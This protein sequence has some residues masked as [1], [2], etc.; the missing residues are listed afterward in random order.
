M[1][2][3]LRFLFII[4]LLLFLGAWLFPLAF[5]DAIVERVKTEANA[6]LDAELNFE[7]VDLSLISTFPYFGFSLEGLSLDGK[8][9]FEGERLLEVGDFQLKIDLMSVI[10]GE[11]Y[12]IN[13]ISL[14]DVKANLIILENGKSNFDILKA[15][16]SGSPEAEELN[17]ESSPFHMALRSYELENFD[18]TFRDDQSQ[19]LFSLKDLDHQGSGD[20]S[21]SIVNLETQTSISAI[22]FKSEG[23][24]YLKKVGLKADVD[25]SYDQ[26]KEELV[27]AENTMTLN[28][29]Q[30]H[31]DGSVR[32]AE[33]DVHIDM[34]YGSPANSFKDLISLIP[35][36]YYQD[37]SDL[38]TKGQFKLDGLVSGVFNGEKE[39]Y[40]S[41]KL[42]LAVEDA[43]IHYPDLPTAMDNIAI[44][45]KIENLSNKLEATEVNLKS[46][47]ATIG[48][49]PISASFMLKDPMGD[50]NI[51]AEMA[52][53]IDL[54]KISEII[55]LP[56][57]DLAGQIE[58]EFSLATRL[59][60]VEQ[61]NFDL[62]EAEGDIKVKN[63]SAAGDSL[64]LSMEILQS[65][66]TISPQNARLKK[67][68]LR[69]G[70]SD[71][72][73]EGSLDNMLGYA[74]SDD[75]LKGNLN[76]Y[77]TY[78]NM[79]DLLPE[80]EGASEEASTDTT[81][82]TVIRIPKNLDLSLKGRID[83]F[84]Y[85]GLVMKTLRGNVI[86]KDGKADQDLDI[87]ML[88]GSVELKGSYDSKPP[89][90][91]ADMTFK[92]LGCSFFE[93]YQGL[94]MVKSIAP[95]M[96]SI[97]GK[98]SAGLNFQ[99]V[100]GPDM[101]PVLKS[102]NGGGSLSTNKVSG[103]NATMALIAK[104]LNNPKYAQLNVQDVKMQFE[105]ADGQVEVK[106][107][108]FKLA[109][110][111]SDFSGSMGLDQSLDFKLN[112][113]LPLSAIK[114]NGLSSQFSAFSNGV[115]PLSVAISGTASKPNIKPNLGKIAGSLVQ[116]AK[117]QV[118]EKVEKKVEEV[119][120]D[121]NAKLEALV[122]EAE[123]KGDALIAEAQKQG[124]KLKAEAKKQADKVRAGGEDAAQKILKEAGSNPLKQLGAKPLAEQARTEANKQAQ[125]LEDKA[126]QE[127]DKL[128]EAAKAQKEKLIKDAEAKA[129]V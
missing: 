98:Y 24:S 76:F 28:D 59:S 55:P 65:E 124:D 18:F 72:Q 66:L 87:N 95:I 50:P 115:V 63:L 9:A 30:L 8:G 68:D 117:Q 113:D 120:E 2:R 21:Q 45:L 111:P 64:P 79:A 46:A 51:N 40:P 1:K 91:I 103:E 69:F 70:T 17:T 112:T 25:L 88:G 35:A 106:P 58:S 14:E 78:L 82:L 15:D 104:F 26:D 75:K 94:D 101:S 71:L 114:A 92:M 42:D 123:Q 5:K 119:K 90:P 53:L 89:E 116:E 13:K 128:V 129:K 127:A 38:E 57:Y 47:S 54:A 83:E 36:Y 77:S 84:I 99:S 74:L 41:F 49:N 85:D 32:L 7:S 22:N 118:K 6:S 105:I 29:L 44:D 122:K 10:S 86:L 126:A 23:I 19:M 73:L 56:G 81:A 100:L 102:V 121:V 108:D 67:T 93:T 27:L 12:Q 109:G 20:F 16:T 3:I 11:S 33:E 61:E 60:Y 125:A 43:Y 37:F 52:G 110:Y 31:W 4:I 80:S 96:E 62:I 34:T 107:F 97:K 48:D 39:I